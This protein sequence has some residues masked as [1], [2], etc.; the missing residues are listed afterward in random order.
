MRLCSLLKFLQ[1]LGLCEIT[2]RGENGVAVG[3]WLGWLRQTQA[4]STLQC[5]GGRG[6]GL[7]VKAVSSHKEKA[8]NTV[9]FLTISVTGARNMYPHG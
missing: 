1:V 2:V 3:G 4:S 5:S 9:R 6:A 8:E 7:W